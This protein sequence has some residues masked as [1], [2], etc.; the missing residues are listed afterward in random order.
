MLS[1]PKIS[2][3]IPT[4]NRGELLKKA[5]SS[6]L[7]QTF[8]DFELIIVDEASVDNTERIV[9]NF[10]ER[11]DRIKY[12][13]YEVNSG[14][15]SIARN[16]GIAVAKGEYL[17]FLDS[18]DEWLPKKLEMQTRLAEKL[19]LDLIGCN[20]LLVNENS[21][22]I[23]KVI[24][25]EWIRKNL[26]KGLVKGAFYPNLSGLLIRKRSLKDSKWLDINLTWGEDL[27]L[28]IRLI[29]NN[30]KFDF[31]KDY[32]FKY[33]IHTNRIS[34]K[35]DWIKKARDYE[36]IVLKHREFLKEHPKEYS[37]LLRWVARA[38]CYGGMIEK[39]RKYYKES[40]KFNPANYKSF[41]G[42]LISLGGYRSF[43]KLSKA[44]KIL[45]V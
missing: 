34:N 15:P 3:I 36:Y 16:R 4:H 9:K 6:V 17:A 41:V 21:E 30:A 23:G 45:K 26:L 8:E 25:P 1:K 43:E 42:Y 28:V 7:N 13:R 5:I 10:I 40:I 11:D 32:C 35:L 37:E 2:V 18:D 12:L 22:T 27:E 33:T 38:Y 44:Y 19:G 20:Y 39:G 14:K 29:K 24:F 31:V